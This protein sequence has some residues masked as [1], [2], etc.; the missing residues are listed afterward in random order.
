MPYITRHL[1]VFEQLKCDWHWVVVEG[2]AANTNCTAWCRAQGP[3]LSRDGTSEYLNSIIKH[4][5]VK[6]IRRQLWDGKL[7]MCNQAIKEL[8]ESCVLL[9]VDSDE[10]WAA[11]QIDEI[12]SLFKTLPYIYR[13]YFWCN[14]FL[15]PDIVAT[16]TNG[17]G[18]R[19]GEWLRAFRFEPGMKF[20]KHEPPVLA[21]N[22][23]GYSMGRDDTKKFGLVFN[24]FA[25]AL[26][27][28]VAYKERFYGY[29]NAVTNWRRLQA[30][31]RWP[32]NLK[33]FLPWVGE[34]STA[35]KVNL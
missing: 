31:T 1:P 2:A 10:I 12:V 14:Y 25:Y 26:E 9:Q 32:V 18:N 21:G 23:R 17:F 19:I 6:V 5:R 22:S 4:P 20:E 34:G 13:M 15:G 28:S 11:P 35:D 8:K 33:N 30:N 7:S 24:H 3:G 29:R 27:C 16:S